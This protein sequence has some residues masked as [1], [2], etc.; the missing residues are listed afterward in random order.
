MSLLLRHKPQ[1]AHLTMDTEG[2]VDVSELVRNMNRYCGTNTS[3]DEIDQIVRTNDKKR[4]MYSNDKKRIRACQGHSIHV[5][6]GLVPTQPPP[7]LYHGTARQT[8]AIIQKEGIKRMNRQYVQMSDSLNTARSVGQRHGIPVIFQIDAEKMVHDGISIY[9]SENGVWLVDY[10]PP[11][12][13]SLLLSVY[14]KLF[15]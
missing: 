11:K 14:F 10:I 15:I 1:I 3:V 5:D 9:K 13:L 7:I 8:A 4:F 2:W 12:Y 6:L